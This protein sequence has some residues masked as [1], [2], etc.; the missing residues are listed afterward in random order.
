[1]DR[2][3]G[4]LII[5]GHDYTEY[6]T[7]YGG[8]GWARNDLDSDKSTRTK[9]GTMRRDRITTKRKLTLT[10]SRMDR[11]TAAQLDDDLSLLN[12]QVTYEDLHGRQ[13]RMFY[14]ANVEMTMNTAK[15][16]GTNSWTVK[17]ISL[18]EV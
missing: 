1:M 18:T 16:D 13:T 11:A 5:N 2:I 9:D 7:A 6:V 3:T 14:C 8:F 10:L 12:V 15:H 17:N 4:V